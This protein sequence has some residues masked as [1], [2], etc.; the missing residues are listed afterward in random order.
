VR[1]I[2][3]RTRR[4]Y[5]EHCADKGR[6]AWIGSGQGLG[7]FIAGAVKRV[8]TSSTVSSLWST[9]G[10]AAMEDG[11][12]DWFNFAGGVANDIII[13]HLARTAGISY[14]APAIHFH[15]ARLALSRQPRSLP[16]IAFSRDG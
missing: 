10:Q 6:A 1:E 5:V 11:Q 7:Y 8:L 4:V 13:S 3:W 9:R 2:D 15:E 16:R 14:Q 12:V